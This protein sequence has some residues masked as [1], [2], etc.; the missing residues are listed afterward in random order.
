VK[1]ASKIMQIPNFVYFIFFSPFFIF[2]RRL[3]MTPCQAYIHHLLSL[4]KPSLLPR[5]PKKVF[6]STYTP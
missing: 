3:P 6:I 5:L 1:A 4:L 2:K